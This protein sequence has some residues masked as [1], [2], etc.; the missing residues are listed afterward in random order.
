MGLGNLVGLGP[1]FALAESIALFPLD[2]SELIEDPSSV[3]QESV[4]HYTKWLMTKYFWCCC[5]FIWD[6]FMLFKC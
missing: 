6:I 2:A 3:K 1:D 4:Y 5:S